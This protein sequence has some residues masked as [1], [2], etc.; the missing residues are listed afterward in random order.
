MNG[1]QYINIYYN[2]GVIV[3]HCFEYPCKPKID[4]YCEYLKE[5]QT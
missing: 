4:R 1:S 3:I 2:I 5:K